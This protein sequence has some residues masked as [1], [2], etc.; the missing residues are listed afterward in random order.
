M[1][2]ATKIN[3]PPDTQ[4]KLPAT[5]PKNDG[6]SERAML[7]EIIERLGTIEDL[8]LEIAPK[9]DPAQLPKGIPAPE[10]GSTRKSY[11]NGIRRYTAEEVGLVKGLSA[12]GY[13]DIQIAGFMER[14]Q[15]SIYTLLKSP[16]EFQK[17]VPPALP[18]VCYEFIADRLKK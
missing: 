5:P 1:H 18:K 15:T 16:S 12:L 14:P 3:I 17:H 7:Q 2:D 10:P 4:Q 8:L 6:P 11:P 13:N 9:Q